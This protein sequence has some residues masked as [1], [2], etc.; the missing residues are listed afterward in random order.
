MLA[1][2]V[3]NPWTTHFYRG[4]GERLQLLVNFELQ[5]RHKLL[6]HFSDSVL[7]YY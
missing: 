4:L 2:R 5:H 1:N 6:Q 3:V 7:H